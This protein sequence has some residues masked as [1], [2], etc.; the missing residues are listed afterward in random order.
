MGINIVLVDNT[1][2]FNLIEHTIEDEYNINILKKYFLLKELK[3]DIFYPEHHTIFEKA[4]LHKKYLI[5]NALFDLGE[6][7]KLHNNFF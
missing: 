1:C 7:K 6:G 4:I 5:S 3:N 2:L